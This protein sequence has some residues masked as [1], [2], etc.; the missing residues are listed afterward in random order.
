MA[1]VGG[2]LLGMVLEIF[3]SPIKTQITPHNPPCAAAPTS[4]VIA[5]RTKDAKRMVEEVGGRRERC[6]WR[7]GWERLEM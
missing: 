7:G 5:K 4:R 3:D 2:V 1:G 6:G